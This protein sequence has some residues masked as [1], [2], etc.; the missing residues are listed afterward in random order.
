MRI[1]GRLGQKIHHG[2]KIVVGM[3]Q[4]NVAPPDV[5][6]DVRFRF[7][8][9]DR[10]W[11]EALVAQIGAVDLKRQG[12]QPHKIKRPVD[13]VNIFFLKVEDIQ[14]T[15]DGLRRTIFLNFQPDSGAALHLAQLGLDGMQK[16]L[17]LLLVDVEVAVPRDPEQV[18][19]LDPH[20]VKQA[21]DVM[22]NDVAEKDVVILLFCKG[23]DSRQD[24]GHLHDG[25][26]GVQV[27]SF[28]F[29]DYVQALVEQLRERVRGIDRK[30]GKH[31]VN[32]LLKEIGKVFLL[33]FGYVGIGVKA[34]TL[35]FE[36]RLKLLAPVTVLI[37]DHPAHTLA[38]GG[39]RLAGR[40]PVRTRLEGMHL[41]L[42]LEAGHAHLEELVQI[43]TDNAEKF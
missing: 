40:E 8:R 38:D 5:K 35:L 30:R 18:S 41:L 26:I 39:K 31:R 16:I 20:S 4:E 6:K 9:N 25:N 19:S 29:D 3:V 43:R 7:E 12:H 13:A 15:L 24:P 34:K 33:A 23:H 21:F 17:R 22:Q 27:F 11:R 1:F 10:V 2:L 42:L 28:E 37:I 14:Q 32:A 36:L